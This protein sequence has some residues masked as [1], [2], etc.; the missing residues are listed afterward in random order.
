MGHCRYCEESDANQCRVRIHICKKERLEQSTSKVWLNVKEQLLTS[1]NELKQ[2]AVN[3]ENLRQQDQG[4]II[5]WEEI[6]K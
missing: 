4:Q 3:Y 1:L 6:T 5:L 2:W